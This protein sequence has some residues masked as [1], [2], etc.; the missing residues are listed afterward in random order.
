MQG[1]AERA[2]R[3]RPPRPDRHTFILQLQTR[4]KTTMAHPQIV[5]SWHFCDIAIGRADV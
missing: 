4:N 3:C 1:E 5:S 2:L